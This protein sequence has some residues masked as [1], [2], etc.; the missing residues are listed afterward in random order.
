MKISTKGRYALRVMVDLAQNSNGE[1]IPLM[2]IARR[3]GISEKYLEG[4]VSSLA[5]SGL[6]E[7][8]RGKGGGYVLSREPSRY[9]LLEIIESAEGSVA[10]VACLEENAPDCERKQTC[11]TYPM[12]KNLYRVIEDY[13]SG[14]TLEDLARGR[15]PDLEEPGPVPA[16]EN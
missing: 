12:W 1:R 10:P 13:L 7:S 8:V 2:D 9:P 6:V 16:G 5:K 4:I 11:R 14:T 15:L 3:Q